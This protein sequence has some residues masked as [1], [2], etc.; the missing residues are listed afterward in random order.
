MKYSEAEEQEEIEVGKEGMERHLFC[1]RDRLWGD[2][3]A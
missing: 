2:S 3:R 1:V